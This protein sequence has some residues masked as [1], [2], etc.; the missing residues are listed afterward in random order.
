MM[1]IAR[2]CWNN[3]CTP[4]GLHR[5]NVLCHIGTHGNW[6][7][8]LHTNCFICITVLHQVV[9]CALHFIIRLCT[10]PMFLAFMFQYIKHWSFTFLLQYVRYCSLTFL[11]QC[12]HDSSFTFCCNVY[13]TVPLLFVAMC[14][15]LF[16]YF[17]LQCVLPCSLTLFVSICTPQMFLHFNVYSIVP[18]R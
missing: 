3:L 7:H 11:L 9:Q 8:C 17:L 12:V 13:T 14:T 4:I 10:P 1:L 6:K 18:L 5:F 2:M 16:P 15:A